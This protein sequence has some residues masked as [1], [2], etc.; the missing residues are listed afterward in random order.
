ML[1]ALARQERRETLRFRLL[2][3]GE[4]TPVVLPPWA[5]DDKNGPCT[6]LVLLSPPATHFVLHAPPWP[7][8]PDALGSSA[9]ALQLTRCGRERATLLQVFVEMRSPRALIHTL[10]AV[11]DSPPA[12]LFTTL[13]ERDP[14][15]LA[16]PG[17]PGPEPQREPLAE[18]LRRFEAAARNAGALAVD[19]SLLPS[20]GYVRLSLEPGCHRLLA[21]ANGSH[22]FALLLDTDEEQKA[23][24]LPT[25]AN[26]D[27][28]Y[29]RCTVK[30]LRLLASSESAPVEAERQ[31]SV[32][33][34]PLSRGLPRR[35]GL[36]V[37]ERLQNALGGSS[38]PPGL[39]P[40]VM[41]TLG[42][43]GRTSLPRRLL[44]QTC[45][46]AVVAV[47][48]GSAQSLSL[49]VQAGARHGAAG[50]SPDR[51]SARVSFCT[52]RSPAADLEVEARGAGVA[53]QIFLFQMGPARPE[54]P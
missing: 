4:L 28:S 41:T 5:L 6:T 13:P 38:A 37:A 48:R 23:V 3:R 2:E 36:D 25:T 39:G 45:Y 47:V 15:L 53:W 40:L 54:A 42:A 14:G 29:E 31:L 8:L 19:T 20:P 51:P 27:V 50:S 9:G 43:Q 10:V 24:R 46:L 16:P 1:D 12:P 18:R 33:H 30:T 17:D 32:A 35:F 21:G 52:Q 44:P 49:G 34:F 11:G 22:P 26:S 7:G